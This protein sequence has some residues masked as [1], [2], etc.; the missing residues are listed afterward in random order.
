M[1]H[2]RAGLRLRRLGALI[3]L[4]AGA[5]LLSAGGGTAHE[6][7]E[8]QIE[9]LTARLATAPTPELYLRRAD[10][11]RQRRAWE[12]ALADLARAGSLDPGLV[13]IHR[14][15]AEVLLDA[16]R[17]DRALPEIE[18]FL[19]GQPA[20][21]S[22]RVLRARILA[23]LGRSAAA[24][25]EYTR[26]LAALAQQSP[27]EPPNPQLY[28]DRARLLAADPASRE[29]AIRGL[30]EGI[31]RLGP[32]VSLE[33]PAIEL[34]RALRRFDRALA[35]VQELSRG[36]RRQEPWL[37]LRGEILAAAGRDAEARQAYCSALAAIAA[38]P[39]GL[40]ATA[41]TQEIATQARTGLAR[42]AG[43]AG[44]DL[45]AGDQGAPCAR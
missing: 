2:R 34:E 23:G 10:L 24:A 17:P 9:E 15:R 41:S 20:A 18:A 16:G 28:V 38:L 22:G 31:G 42:P 43:A 40:R 4:L 33:L 6:A 3:R 27:N 26:A 21:A 8:H 29:E 36:A 12:P 35:R 1:I 32:V 7:L 19:A 45:P 44:D 37:V 13:V 30:D 11:Y 5:L 14:S 39:A 25:A